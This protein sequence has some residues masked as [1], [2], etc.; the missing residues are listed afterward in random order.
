MGRVILLLIISFENELSWKTS[1]SSSPIGSHFSVVGCSVPFLVKNHCYRETSHFWTSYPANCNQGLSHWNAPSY[2]NR[3]VFLKQYLHGHCLHQ[4]HWWF[5]I[6]CRIKTITRFI[7]TWISR[8]LLPIH[9][10]ASKERA[11]DREISHQECSRDKF[12]NVA[13]RAP[14]VEYKNH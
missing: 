12:Q 2:V 5:P 6:F 11:R 4:N 3:M 9:T 8:N 14:F 7:T 10:P 13:P 1:K